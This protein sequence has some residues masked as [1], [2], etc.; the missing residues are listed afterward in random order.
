MDPQNDIT[1]SNKK[2]QG[3]Y[4]LLNLEIREGNMYE[5]MK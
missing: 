1:P 2:N 4:K 5:G 3:P